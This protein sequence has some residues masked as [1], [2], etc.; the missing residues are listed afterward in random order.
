MLLNF[1]M[2]ALYYKFSKLKRVM[3]AMALDRVAKHM[4]VSNVSELEREERERAERRV[5]AYR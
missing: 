2:L 1:M 5:K 4:K 3:T